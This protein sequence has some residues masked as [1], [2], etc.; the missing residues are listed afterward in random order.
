MKKN[1]TN[2]YKEEPSFT[3]EDDDKVTF[4]FDDG[5]A[6][7]RQP[8][9]YY[10]TFFQDVIYLHIFDLGLLSKNKGEKGNICLC[11]F[12]HQ[13]ISYWEL[14]PELNVMKNNKPC[15]CNLAMTPHF[16]GII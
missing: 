9:E 13:L 14:Y 15:G 12:Q 6:N 10:Y 8:I 4:E 16:C 1:E 7:E 2:C 3:D 11:T 5:H